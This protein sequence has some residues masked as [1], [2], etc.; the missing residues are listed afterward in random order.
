MS[1]ELGK[2]S[3][4]FLIFFHGNAEDIFLASKMAEPL[5]LKFNINI[6]I[7]EY[8]SY[9]I[10][11]YQKINTDILLENTLIVC[12]VIKEYFYPYD[13]FMVD[14]LEV[15]LRFTLQEKENQKL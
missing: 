13:L 12:D 9:S 11:S 5:R 14:Q 10:Y 2:L 8:P 1:S 15:Y 4:N 7:V 6:I 3:S